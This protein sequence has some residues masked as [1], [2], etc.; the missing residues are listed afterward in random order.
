M[1]R[2]TRDETGTS[3]GE[4]PRGLFLSFVMG[5]RFRIPPLLRHGSP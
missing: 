3:G 4:K 2:Q 1:E 5:V